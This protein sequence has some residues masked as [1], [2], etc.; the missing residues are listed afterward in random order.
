[1]FKKLKSLFIEENES[2]K[3]AEKKAPVSEKEA[4]PVAEPS[5]NVPVEV[6]EGQVTEKFMNILLGALEKNNIDGFDYLEFKQS[7]QSLS[8]MP[9]DEATR[10]KSALATAQT[11][12][13]T[14]Q[15]LVDTAQFYMNV[16]K[17][18]EQ[19]FQT[20]LKNQRSKQ[21]GNREQSIQQ[22]SAMIQKKSE[23]IKQMTQEIEEHQKQ[24]EKMRTEIASSTVKVGN[25]K[26]N[27][28]A[29]YNVLAGKI[30]QDVANIKKYLSK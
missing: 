25:T 6:G 20:A 1:M 15:K 14:P 24:M 22:L 9:M 11:M 13:A 4:D 16:L 29:T 12:E 21:I 5:P 8:K 28:D 3:P 30:Q 2:A 10:F 26:A 17:K 27:F 7:L 19:K 23:Q 18:E